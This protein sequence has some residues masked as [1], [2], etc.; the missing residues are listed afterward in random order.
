LPP[1]LFLDN[2]NYTGISTIGTATVNPGPASV[3]PGYFGVL[4]GFLVNG[5]G[6]AGMG[7]I[8]YDLQTVVTGT[9]TVTNTNTLMVGTATAPGQ[10]ISG[11]QSL[12][13]RYRGSL[14][15]VTSGT[16]GNVNALW[17]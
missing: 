8:A 9:G 16:A 15:I 13:I 5:T 6:T 10:V 12:G 14:V 1:P 2:C 7:I 17:D 3:E 11:P 4:Y